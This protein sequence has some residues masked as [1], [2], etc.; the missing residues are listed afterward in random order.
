MQAT[1]GYNILY[2][3]YTPC[4]MYAAVIDS[5]MLLST[6]EYVIINKYATLHRKTNDLDVSLIND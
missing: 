3:Y 4:I 2:I 6:E 1:N 5:D